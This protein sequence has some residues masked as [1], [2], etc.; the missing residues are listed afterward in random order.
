L[1]LGDQLIGG[2]SS[3]AT[4]L[5][6]AGAYNVLSSGSFQ[7]WQAGLNLNIPLGF[8]KELSTIRFYQLNLARE[9]ARLQDEELE[10]S[11]QL[12][13]AVRNLD[14]NYDLML[15][16]LN[17]RIAAEREVD[18]VTAAYRAGKV[19]FDLL[20]N[21]QQRRSD[22]ES[23]YYRNVADYNR[24]ILQVH[25]RKGSLLEYNGI[26]LTEGPWPAKA[27][28]DAHR[29]ARQRD[30]SYYLNYGYTRPAVISEGPYRQHTGNGGTTGQLPDQQAAPH[31]APV[32]ELPAPTPNG[33]R[34]PST[35][36]RV[37]PSGPNRPDQNFGNPNG[38]AINQPRVPMANARRPQEGGFAWGGLGLDRP[39]ENSRSSS[40][41]NTSV[42]SDAPQTQLAGSAPASNRISNTESRL[43]P[44][45]LARG[46]ES[47]QPLTESGDATGERA[48]RRQ[49]NDAAAVDAR[50]PRIVADE[51][52]A[53]SY[54]SVAD[55]STGTAD[56]IPSG[57][58]RTNR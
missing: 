1:G 24:A 5:Q 21:A 50:R 12:G 43:V 34:Y 4:G 38:P 17:R 25:Y 15:S 6:D 33:T 46:E 23:A 49:A 48:E 14:Y 36:N 42:A 35:S 40:V 54:E 29:L 11:H 56:R 10:L 53:T 22:A 13:D 39:A 28:F 52:K 9:R 57:W 8:R 26:Y 31:E 16:N 47:A 51:W 20:L 55:P 27:Q 7:E 30:A 44:R 41:S 18:A 45:G 2:S 3:L 58:Q 32:E 37:R 19:T